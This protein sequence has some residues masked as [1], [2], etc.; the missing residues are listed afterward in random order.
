MTAANLLSYW[1]TSE[2]SRYMQ[3]LCLNHLRFLCFFAAH[4]AILCVA[5][6]GQDETRR[7][8][9]IDFYG[10][11]GL[12]LDQ[13]R[14]A[15]PIHVGDRFPERLE[16]IDGIN[17]AVISVIGRPPLDVERVCCDAHGNYM[18]YVG[19]PG[20]SIKHTK[21]NPIPKGKTRLP[22]QVVELYEQ[23]MDAITAAVLKGNV[24]E[25]S[26]KGFALS[27]TDPA[28]RAKQ[29]EVRAYAVQHEKL[30]L[31]VLDSSSEARQRIIA[32][33]LLGY[34]RQSSQQITYLVRASHDADET[35]RNNATRALGVLAKSSPKVAAR[36]PAGGFI[37]MLSSGS[38]SDR[39][40]AGLVLSSLTRSRDPKLLAQLRSEALVSLIE[41]ARWR[42]AG[43]AYTARIL[44][45]RIAGIQEDRAWQL[46][47]AD[48][49][50]EIIN[51]LP[52]KP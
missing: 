16:T 48:N 46:A 15:L 31:G 2:F 14:S 35:V 12:D 8:G 21:L 38:W 43:H 49:A 7:I 17:K 9:S 5:A 22:A 40:K 4:I 28:L 20:A 19:L 18:I 6:L 50:D 11:A 27:T 10:Y 25:D 1:R 36:I 47:N 45:A 24:R 34:A 23:T 39:N 3:S 52:L 51:A 32:A 26:S 41:M 29:M 13:I 33:Y 44:L 37:K 42:S 30:I